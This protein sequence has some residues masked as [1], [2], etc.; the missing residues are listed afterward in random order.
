[1]MSWGSLPISFALAVAPPCTRSGKGKEE[2]T[3]RRGGKVS[4][5]MTSRRPDGIYQAISAVYKL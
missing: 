3:F 2:K 1:M 5:V 4:Y